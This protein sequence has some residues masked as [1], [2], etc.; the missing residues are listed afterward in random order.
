MNPL[1]DSSWAALMIGAIGALIAFS[2]IIKF[3]RLR[4]W[5]E[6]EGLQTVSQSL[7]RSGDFH[8]VVEDGEK[9][10]FTGSVNVGGI[11]A[12]LVFRKSEV[13][14][15]SRVTMAPAKEVLVTRPAR[16]ARPER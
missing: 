2:Y 8:V 14:W 13:T 1:S 16:A 11:V 12:A 4:R 5:A 6:S 10:R 15:D 7:R 3:R 9:H